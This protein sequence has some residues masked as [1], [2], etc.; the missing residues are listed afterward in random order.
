MLLFEN[1]TLPLSVTIGEIRLLA[2]KRFADRNVAFMCS[3]I[4]NKPPYTR[5]NCEV[6]NVRGFHMHIY[7]VYNCNP[8]MKGF[9]IYGLGRRVKVLCS[10]HLTSFFDA[11]TLVYTLYHFVC[12][13]CL[14]I[15]CETTYYCTN[16][17]GNVTDCL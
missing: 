12:L 10:V 7:L 6:L 14:P 15:Y 8:L 5:N 9:Q 3:C 2:F 4:Q 16:T 1:C 11:W 17:V 13:P